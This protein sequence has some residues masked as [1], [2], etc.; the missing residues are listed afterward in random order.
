MFKKIEKFIYKHNILFLFILSA[1][2]WIFYFKYRN[3]CHCF[4]EAE[5]ECFIDKLGMGAT[6]TTIIFLLYFALYVKKIYKRINQ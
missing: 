5:Q 2:L 4:A 1:V 6:M 3:L